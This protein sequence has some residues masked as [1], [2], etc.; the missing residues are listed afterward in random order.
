VNR[1]KQG[2]SNLRFLFEIGNMAQLGPI[3]SEIRGIDDVFTAERAMPYN[4]GKDSP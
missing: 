4:A 3:L 2:I 1:D